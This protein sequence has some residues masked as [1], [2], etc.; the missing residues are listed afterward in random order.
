MG[1]ERGPESAL[2]LPCLPQ[3][4]VAMVKKVPKTRQKLH[5]GQKSS[6]RPLEDILP[7]TPAKSARAKRKRTP[8]PPRISPDALTPLA[9]TVLVPAQES[10]WSWD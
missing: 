5:F 10:E 3:V 1:A 6:A 4:H 2:V 8:S 9:K 7:G